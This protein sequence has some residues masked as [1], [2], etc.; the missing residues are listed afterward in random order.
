[1]ADRDVHTSTLL[2]KL[3]KTSDFN[4]F[5]NNN[6]DVVREKSFSEYISKLCADSGLIPEHIIKAAQIDRT[7]GHQLF[8]G[9]R[10][11]SRDK[12][13]QLAFGFGMTLDETQR[14]LLAAEK[15]QLYPKV[16]R[17]AAIIFCLTKR[18]SVFEVQSLLDSL[19]LSLLGDN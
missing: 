5:I 18:L 15:S 12:V 7:Y 10:K 17:D 2:R 19:D 6:A 13:I 14:L 3:V 8:N 16:K 9:T 11:P 1:M 4:T